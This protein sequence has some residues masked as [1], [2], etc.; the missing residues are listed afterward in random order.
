MYH[1]R[2]TVWKLDIVKVKQ[3]FEKLLEWG[4]L[5]TG[6]RIDHLIIVIVAPVFSPRFIWRRKWRREY[7]VLSVERHLH[8]GGQA[9][10]LPSWFLYLGYSMI[11]CFEKRTNEMLSLPQVLC[12]LILFC[13]L[14]FCRKIIITDNLWRLYFEPNGIYRRGIV[15]DKQGIMEPQSEMLL[16]WNLIQFLFTISVAEMNWYIWNNFL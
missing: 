5:K 16:K 13:F 2:G 15:L 7:V 11:K 3:R 4:E 6:R 10:R 9:D 12:K 1:L 14:P 8:H